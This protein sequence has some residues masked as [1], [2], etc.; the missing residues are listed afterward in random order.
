MQNDSVMGAVGPVGLPQDTAREVGKGHEEIFGTPP[1][2][3]PLREKELFD[4][5]TGLEQHPELLEAMR[6]IN[7]FNRLQ[8]ATFPA[9]FKS[10]EHMSVCAPTGAGRTNVPLLTIFR[11]IFSV[12]LQKN[13]F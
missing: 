7:T 9:A 13:V 6:G 11:E 10:D 2:R 3:K 12:K 5:A 8:N 1:L 4:V